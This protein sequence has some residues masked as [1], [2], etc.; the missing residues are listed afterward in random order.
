MAHG[1]AGSSACSWQGCDGNTGVRCSSRSTTRKVKLRQWL[2]GLTRPRVGRHSR[3]G[4]LLQ[5]ARDCTKA[6]VFWPPGNIKRAATCVYHRKECFKPSQE[7]PHYLEAANDIKSRRHREKQVAVEGQAAVAAAAAAAASPQLPPVVPHKLED[8]LGDAVPTGCA[9]AAT[10]PPPV[11]PPMFDNTLSDVVPSGGAAATAKLPPVLPPVLDNLLSKAIPSGRAAATAAAADPQP[12]LPS[13][14]DN[15]LNHS[16]PFSP[17]A[18]DELPPLLP[19]VVENPPSNSICIGGGGSGGPSESAPLVKISSA[20]YDEDGMKIYDEAN[21]A[22]IPPY[23]PTAAPKSTEHPH[24]RTWGSTRGWEL[25]D[26]QKLNSYLERARKAAEAMAKQPLSGTPV[27]VRKEVGPPRWGVVTEE[28]VEDKLMVSVRFPGA[29]AVAVARADIH[30]AQTKEL[31]LEVLHEVRMGAA[32][33]GRGPIGAFEEKQEED[34]GGGEVDGAPSTVP[35][36]KG[37][38][39]GKGK[40]K[41]KGADQASLAAAL[42]QRRLEAEAQ[43]SKQRWTNKQVEQLE[44]AVEAH[45][46]VE[47]LQIVLD[48]GAVARAVVDKTEAEVILMYHRFYPDHETQ[49]GVAAV[50]KRLLRQAREREAQEKAARKEIWAARIRSHQQGVSGPQ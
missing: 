24:G 46:A 41:G 28:A 35:P 42:L 37:D 23:A 6:A 12:V 50:K 20:C 15:P 1:I 16:V 7:P 43:D 26:E 19:L 47:D 10:E 30:P 8:P 29:G 14:L 48:L 2:Q 21:E 9:S 33:G 11:W 40:G 44:E 13:V 18:A 27:W 49:D 17:A 32:D 4:S 31:A 45:L 38:G 34:D 22:L 36:G 25:G 5:Q 39:N 3:C